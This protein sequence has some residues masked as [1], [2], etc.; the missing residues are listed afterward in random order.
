MALARGGVRLRAAWCRAPVCSSALHGLVL[1]TD[2][3]EPRRRAYHASRKSENVALYGISVAMVALG[4]K[5]AVDAYIKHAAAKEAAEAIRQEEEKATGGD[6]KKKKAD[7]AK[8]GGE[9]WFATFL[10]GILGKSFY[11][12][13]FEDEMTR[14]EAAL[15]LGIRE[16]APKDKVREAHRRLAML[17]HPDTGGSTFV[18]SKINEA[19]EKLMGAR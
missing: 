9:N 4:G 18:A 2:R 19:K 10:T 11:E 12:G 5:F 3:E 15:I 16:S 1:D 14:R 13:G 8:E 6:T 7:D 17:N